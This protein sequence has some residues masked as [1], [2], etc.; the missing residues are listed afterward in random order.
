MGLIQ[1]LFSN[2][3]SFVILAVLLLYS[4][5]A[6]EVAHG[7]VAHLFGDDTAKYYGRL[8]LN[9]IP[10]IDPL[11]MLMLLLVGFGW[12]RPVPV[13]YYRLRN[14]RVGLFAVSLA[15]CLANILIASVAIFFLQFPAIKYS[16]QLYDIFSKLAGINIMLGAFN[17]IPIPPLDGSKIIM[18]FLP[19]SGQRT[20]AR[21]EKYGFFVIIILLYTGLLNPLITLMQNLIYAA[22][23][24]LFG[25]FNK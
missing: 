7:W 9:P 11:G 15:G 23:S 14:S 5:I 12:A 2:P 17:L 21:F 13:D 8:T 20:M 10:H 18:G 22:I 25:L 16:Q 24:L 6:H 4:I 1:L 3:V 19:A